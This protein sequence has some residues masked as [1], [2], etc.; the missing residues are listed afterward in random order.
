MS[1]QIFFALRIT[2]LIWV[3]PSS[4]SFQRSEAWRLAQQDDAPIWRQ[5][6]VPYSQIPG[7][8]KRAVVA[9]EDSLFTQHGGVD[10]K[11]IEQAAKRNARSSKRTYGGST[12]SQQLA[13]NLFLSG[14]R[15]LLRK[16][17]ELVVTLM[18]E[19]LLSKERIFEIYLNHVEWGAGVFGIEAAAQHYFNKPS[20]RLTSSEAARLAVMLPAPKRFEKNLQSRYLTRRSQT[21]RSRMNAVSIP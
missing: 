17:Q 4:T 8:I 15:N 20:S 12:I 10:W 2:T 16:G 3:D 6:W 13:K 14:E 9:S 5:Q 7:H 11:A 21:I 19:Q 18:L 1:L